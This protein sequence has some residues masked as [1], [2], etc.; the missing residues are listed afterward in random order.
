MVN[1]KSTGSYYTPS[2]LSEFLT[3]HIFAK[4]L[5]TG[6]L[7]ILEPSCGD[8]S[9]VSALSNTRV[10]NNYKSVYIDL[11]EIDKTELGKSATIAHNIP[12]LG[13]N[14]TATPGDYLDYTGSGYTLII[15]NPPYVN[16][17]LLPSQQVEKCRNI[18]RKSIP[19]FGEIKNIWPTFLLKS[20]SELADNGVLCYVLPG[21]ILQVNYTRKIREFLLNKFER[22]EIFSFNELIFPGIEQDVIAF[23]GVKKVANETDKGVSFYQ[24]E[25][26]TDLKIPGYVEKHSNVH[27]KNLNK[28]TNYILSDNELNNIDTVV[29]KLNLKST[30]EYCDRIEVGIVTAA[31]KFFIV[32]DNVVNEYKLK[33][34]VKPLIQKGTQVQNSIRITRESFKKLKEKNKRVNFL[35]FKP[36]PEN[37][38]NKGIQKYI[39]KGVALKL[40]E[41]YK[42]KLRNYW[43][44][45]PTVWVS[46]GMFIK[47]SH[48]YPRVLINEAEAY[49]TDSFYRI[50]MKDQ[51]SI[52]NFTFSFYNTLTFVLAELEGRYYGGG[53]LELIPTEFKR[54]KIPYNDKITNDQLNNLDKLFRDEKPLKEILEYSDSILLPTLTKEERK[55]LSSILKKLVERRLKV[56]KKNPKITYHSLPENSLSKLPA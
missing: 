28:W 6:P 46:E 37:K 27:R 23:I 42:M 11:L 33:S 22:I 54:L 30:K 50:M 15:G 25:K 41:Q 5:G 9:F 16:K 35:H 20:I 14:I 7:K 44:C 19:D 45:V 4:H 18:C 3:K 12:N 53:V 55:K 1:D 24:V 52:K 29:K 38:Q 39:E 2:I 34:L 8:G 31:N 49:V 32:E 51:Y 47:R 26:L 21:E 56:Q 17:K 10:L 43:Y 13:I 36:K 40:H 48:L